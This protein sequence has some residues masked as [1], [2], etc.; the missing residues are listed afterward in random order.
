M[1]IAKCIDWI[2]TAFATL[3]FMRFWIALE[4]EDTILR[5]KENNLAKM[6]SAGIVK[7]LD[8]RLLSAGVFAVIFGV[9]IV[10]FIVWTLSVA[11]KTV[12]ESVLQF[13][14]SVFF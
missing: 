14:G 12:F 2:S 6:K 8:E 7:D 11:F 1:K 5:I 13:M 9:I 10:A 4:L 3:M